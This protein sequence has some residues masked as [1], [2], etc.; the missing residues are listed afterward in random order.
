MKDLQGLGRI[1]IY[2]LCST[3]ARAGTASGRRDICCSRA[4]IQFA[5]GDVRIVVLVHI[6]GTF[7]VFFFKKNPASV[8]KN[9]DGYRRNQTRQS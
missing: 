8:K 4:L 7:Q 2:Y 3:S 1:I 9:A 6:K 5:H